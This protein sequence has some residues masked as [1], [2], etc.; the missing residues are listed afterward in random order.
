[1]MMMMGQSKI[2]LSHSIDIFKRH[3]ETHFL[4]RPS[5]SSAKRLCISKD[6]IQ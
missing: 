4:R 5:L 3:L 1:M 2:R 6:I